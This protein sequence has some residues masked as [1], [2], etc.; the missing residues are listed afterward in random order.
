MNRKIKIFMALGAAFLLSTAFAYADESQA[1]SLNNSNMQ[2]TSL[3]PLTYNAS[4]TG[5]YITSDGRIYKADGS[6]EV[7]KKARWLE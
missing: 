3:L 1:P 7:A 5:L 6:A 4:S 2:D